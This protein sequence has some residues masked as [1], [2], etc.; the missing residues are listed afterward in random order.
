MLEIGDTPV[1][2]AN[3]L[4]FSRS[5]HSLHLPPC[6]LLVPRA[7]DGTRSIGV[8]GE[9]RGCFVGDEAAGVGLGGCDMGSG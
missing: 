1:G 9:E 8:Q 5:E 3:G 6:L 2:Y 4:G 7:V